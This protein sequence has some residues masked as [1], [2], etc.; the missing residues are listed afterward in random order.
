MSDAAR[1]GQ[2]LGLAFTTD[3]VFG[4]LLQGRSDLESRLARVFSAYARG[5]DG[6]P[7]GHILLDPQHRAA[8]L[9]LPPGHWKAPVS[10]LVRSGPQLIRAFGSGVVRALR[11]LTVVENQH[12]SEPHWYLEAIGT[13]PPARG[14]GIGAT[15]LAPVLATCD[16]GGIPAYLESSNPR[17]IPFYE[18]HGFVRRPLFGL[19]QGCPVITPMWRDPRPPTPT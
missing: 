2:V 3:P 9:W 17:N 4:W 7:D 5:V 18:R 19:P 12:P 14:Q 11:L 16:A 8:A 6:V 15:L 1:A 13:I 10:E